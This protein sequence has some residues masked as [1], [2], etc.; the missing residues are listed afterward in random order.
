MN[1]QDINNAQVIELDIAPDGKTVWVNI[2]G[3]CVVRC[4]KPAHIIVRD[5]RPHV[6]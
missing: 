4:N 3:I 1:Q 5:E 6:D 2:D